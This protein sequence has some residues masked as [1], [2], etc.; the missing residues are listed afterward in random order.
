MN[1]AL[2]S[3]GALLSSLIYVLLEF[4]KK[5]RVEEKKN[6]FIVSI[7]TFGENDKT[8]NPRNSKNP[9]HEKHGENFT[10]THHHPVA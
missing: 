3:C 2:L 6:E 7:S 4:L 8:I 1:K 10:K 9:Q 5:R